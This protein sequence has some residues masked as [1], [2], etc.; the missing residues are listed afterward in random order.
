MK[1]SFL[2]SVIMKDIFLLMRW[3]QSE[4]YHQRWTQVI[5][6]PLIRL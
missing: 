5:S 6:Y 3:Q 2:D 1:E 4:V